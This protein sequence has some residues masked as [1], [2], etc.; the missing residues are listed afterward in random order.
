[1]V[2]LMMM[3]IGLVSPVLPQYARTFGGSI[4]MVGLLIATFGIARLV[5]DIP[6]GRLTDWVGRRAVLIAGPLIQAMGSVASGLA[7]SY[8]QLLAF[9]LVQGV[10]SA[11][12]TTA[13][14]I[15]LADLSTPANRGQ[16]M[17]LYQ[18]SLLLGAGLGPTLGGF[19]AQYFGIRA[20]FFVFGS[21]AT[22]AALWAHLR[23][24]ET[25]PPSRAP[26][27][28]V[29]GS[30]ASGGQ[31]PASPARGLKPLLCDVNFLLISMVT[32]GF[33]F[34]RTGARSQILP[35]LGSDPLGLSPGQIGFALTLASVL[36]FATLFVSGGL[37]DRLGRKAVIT[38]GCIV[39][40]ASLVVLAESGNYLFLF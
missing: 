33:F 36:N 2:T 11:M 16:I 37:S 29:P 34:M 38:P 39:A 24:P 9:R 6:A 21:L 26:I 4:T 7:G 8:W 31:R 12:C 3:G 32:F 10:G 30:A 28:A 5:V 20:P 40:A 22:V 13:A 18:G 35:L 19:V 15:T 17:S 1:M 25:R 27:V 14:M 23:L